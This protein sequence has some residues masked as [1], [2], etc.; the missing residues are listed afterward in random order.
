MLGFSTVFESRFFKSVFPFSFFVEPDESGIF[1]SRALGF[2]ESSSYLAS[3]S[4]FYS[5]FY[6]SCFLVKT[7]TRKNYQ[8]LLL[9]IAYFACWFS[10]FNGRSWLHCLSCYCSVLYFLKSS[11]VYSSYYSRGRVGARRGYFYNTFRWHD[12]P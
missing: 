3:F 10:P 1:P 11:V 8:D 4:A 6:F 9:F 2:F 5:T 7:S 12:Q